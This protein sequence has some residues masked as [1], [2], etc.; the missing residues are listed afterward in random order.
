V[1]LPPESGADSAI[2]ICKPDTFPAYPVSCTP[3]PEVHDEHLY[4]LLG[5]CGKVSGP[6]VA[7][8]AVASAH[9]LLFRK[10]GRSDCGDC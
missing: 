8:D 3:A 5:E 9:C 2:H 10:T 4:V 7:E 6:C 1:R